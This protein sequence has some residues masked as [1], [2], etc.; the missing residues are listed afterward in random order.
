MRE[1]CWPAAC[2]AFLFGMCATI[3]IISA[4]D[5]PPPLRDCD[6]AYRVPPHLV[7]A[8]GHWLC[9]QVPAGKGG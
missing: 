1:R 2:V 3:V 8:N 6:M 5:P 4:I 9:F 7:P